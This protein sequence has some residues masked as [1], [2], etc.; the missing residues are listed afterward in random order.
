MNEAIRAALEAEMEADGTI[1]LIGEDVSVSVFGTTAGLADRYGHERVIDT[2]I[3]EGAFLGMAV[4]AAA[5]GLKPVAELM[6]C[7]FLGVG[8]DAVLNQAGKLEFL[9]NGQ[10][11]LPLVI[12][13]TVGAGDSSA[14]QH[15]QS[16]QHV[17][18]SIAG[19]KVAMPA[20]PAD[21]IG[22]TLSAIRDPGP[23]IL[24]EHKLLYAIEGETPKPLRAVPLGRAR[25]VREGRDVSLVA[26]GRM[27]HLADEA[28]GILASRGMTADVIDLRTLQPLD[29]AT[30]LN[31]LR[32]TGRLLVVDEGAACCGMAA[33][34][35]AL[36]ARKA[37]DTLKTAPA[38]ITPPH[39]PVPFSPPLEAAWLPDAEEI[40]DTAHR[41][42]LAGRRQRR[43]AQ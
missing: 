19:L 40:A 3:S 36:A 16:L 33:E 6:F 13:A 41:L 34:I 27:V 4:G 12:R 21:A 25:V 7:D 38:A 30:I 20:T 37:F 23:V 39:M 14:A 35:V 9:S 5:T 32:K 8:F 15:S 1:V 22:L 43:G 31:S 42:M 24:L 17:F 28:A 29:E 11:P 26:A 2:P 10:L 18:A